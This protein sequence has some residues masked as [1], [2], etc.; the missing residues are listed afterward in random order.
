MILAPPSPLQAV[1]LVGRGVWIELVRRKDLWVLS[2]LM[3]V[4]LLGVLVVALVGIET[5][6]TAT[7]LLNLGLSLSVFSAHLLALLL[8]ARQVPDDIENRTLYPLLAKPVGRTAY[9]LGKWAACSL[10]GMLVFAVLGGLAWVCTPRMEPVFA[11]MALQMIVLQAA[12][13]SLL[14]AV[15]VL[16]SLVVPK[17][18]NIVV[19]GLHLVFGAKLM[20]FVQMRLGDGLAGRAGEWVLGYLPNFSKL[21]LVTRTTDGIVALPAG[22]FLGLMLYA[23]VLTAAFLCGAVLV[24][25]RRPL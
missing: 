1:A 3:G 17:G 22:E 9:L 4:F 13:I 2:I 20:S 8:A 7:F 25:E 12:S 11:P 16:L 14:V 24:F 15:G 21:Q 18:M 10:S 5:P 19:C 23:I 6:S